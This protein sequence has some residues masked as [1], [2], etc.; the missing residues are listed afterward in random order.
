M[1]NLAELCEY[2]TFSLHCSLVAYLI[3]RKQPKSA[4]ETKKN[5]AIINFF[6]IMICWYYDNLENNLYNMFKR[7]WNVLEIH[8]EKV[9]IIDWLWTP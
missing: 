1:T 9:V 7:Y 6:H 2:M 4:D 3:Q 5:I 8:S